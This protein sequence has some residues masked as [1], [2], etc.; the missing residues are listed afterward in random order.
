MKG[1]IKELIAASE[2][3]LK[4]AEQA[5][6]ADDLELSKS[7]REEAQT[8]F[9]KANELKQNLDAST[10]L[11]E[12]SVPEEEPKKPAP[13]SEK[14]EKSEPARLPF[15]YADGGDD[16]PQDDFD[17]SV[18]SIRYGSEDAAVNAVIKDVYGS[19]YYDNREKQQQAFVK[20]IRGGES[21][22]NTEEY[23]LLKTII[24]MPDTMRNEITAGASVKDLKASTLIEANNE[25]GGFTVPEDYRQEIIS[26]L[27][28]LTVV[29]PRARVVST[30]RDAAEWP[31]LQG[32][33][34]LYTSA[35]RVTWIDETP[36]DE[37]VAATNP[38][39]GMIRVPVHTVMARVDL[40]RNL[41]ED[42]AFNLLDVLADLF[43]EAMA[44]DEDAQFLTGT[45]AGRPEGILGAR[46]GAEEIP[47]AGI[48]TVDTGASSTITADGLFDLAYGLAAQYRGNAAFIG[49]RLTHRDV[50]KL[51][52]SQNQYLWAPGLAPG[53]PS[54]LLG[55][56][57]L[58]SENMPAIG[59]EKYP[60]LYG[61]LRGYLVVDR[62]GMAIERAVDTGT[63]GTNTTAI[64][65]RRR[66]GGKVIEPWRF[67]AHQVS[68]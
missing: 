51:K 8:L 34:D 13:T 20:Y 53:E 60:L 7:K 36:S 40:S 23:Q 52:D 28:G 10:E 19:E 48:A 29:R 31:K 49:A 47:V 43:A 12:L 54:Q 35:V 42:S 65:A 33:D 18:Y 62:V 37:N 44:I 45:G 63:I 6:L 21:R 59:I 16:E 32:G 57:F 14:T 66:L 38:T 50:R 15:D 4:E 5:V 61:D 67:Q 27:S 46:A 58:E 25:L 26:R 68:A 22:L 30:V 3:L 55:N 2:A 41:L 1:K 24:L 39:F 17:K 64:F 11:G 9:A 56:P